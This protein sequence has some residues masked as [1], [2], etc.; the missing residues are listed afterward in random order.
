MWVFPRA[1]G[2]ELGGEELQPSRLGAPPAGVWTLEWSG[3]WGDCAGRLRTIWA[4]Q[5]A[6][7]GFAQL[8]LVSSAGP[9]ATGKP[10]VKD[11]GSKTT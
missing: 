6:G 2:W 3:Y 8:T 4:V 5:E 10:V 9:G 7:V 1:L 11:S